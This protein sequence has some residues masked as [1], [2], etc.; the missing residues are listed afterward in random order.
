MRGASNGGF[1][2]KRS[3]EDILMLLVEID[4]E[5]TYVRAC[6][7]VCTDTYARV[8]GYEC[9]RVLMNVFSPCVVVFKPQFPVRPSALPFSCLPLC[10]CA[11][12]TYLNY[13][14]LARIMPVTIQY[15]YDL[16]SCI[17]VQLDVGTL[18]SLSLPIWVVVL[19]G[20]SACSSSLHSFLAN[21]TSL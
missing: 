9:I 5:C 6:M 19:I 7:R 8:S 10:T 18:H 15:I 11:R 21:T 3:K 13:I 1:S 14:H 20:M 17:N 12:S 4:I 2:L 16:P